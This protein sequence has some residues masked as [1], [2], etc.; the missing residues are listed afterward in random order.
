MFVIFRPMPGHVKPQVIDRGQVITHN[1]HLGNDVVLRVQQLFMD[2][3]NANHVA[4]GVCVWV[5]WVNQ[6][7]E[8]A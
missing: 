6:A 5:L 4:A 2:I 8:A 1:L 7:F 3:V